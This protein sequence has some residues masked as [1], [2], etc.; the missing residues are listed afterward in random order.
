MAITGLVEERWLRETERPR[1]ELLA[2]RLAGVRDL[3]GVLL[4]LA[5]LA[6]AARDFCRWAKDGFAFIARFGAFFIGA[7]FLAAIALCKN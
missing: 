4:R 6:A 7:F 5:A 2:P 1:C 3:K